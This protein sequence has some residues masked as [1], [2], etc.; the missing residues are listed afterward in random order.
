[1]SDAISMGSTESPSRPGKVWIVGIAAVIA[2]LASTAWGTF[3]GSTL[4]ESLGEYLV[5]AGSIGVAAAVIFVLVGRF[6]RKGEPA[7][8]ARTG[9]I[10]GVLGVVTVLVFWSGLP[11][12]FGSAAVLAGSEARRT[13]TGGSRAAAITAMVVGALAVAGAVFAIVTDQLAA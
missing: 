13:A 7:R 5:L 10:T 2:A 12:L 3:S 1:M 8:S 11:L 9:L 6:L 4:S